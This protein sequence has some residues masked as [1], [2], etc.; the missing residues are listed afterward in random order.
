MDRYYLRDNHKGE[1][2]Y[3]KCYCGHIWE[4]AVSEKMQASCP[5]C[6]GTLRINY[7][8]TAH[9]DSKPYNYDHKSA[10]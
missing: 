9:L 6:H 5:S 4:E 2:V 7:S 1:H 3:A 10:E 8:L